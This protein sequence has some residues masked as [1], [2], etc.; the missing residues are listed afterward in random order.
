MRLKV[1]GSAI[2]IRAKSIR[3]LYSSIGKLNYW[4][5]IVF[6]LISFG[7]GQAI[8]RSAPMDRFLIYQILFIPAIVIA[9]K[10]IKI[11]IASAEKYK[12]MTASHPT[13]ETGAYISG[14]LQSHWAVPGV[15]AISSLYI[16]STISLKYVALN[17]TGYYALIM[18][19]FV[20]ISSVLGQ[21]CYIYYLLLLRK[22]FESENFK[23][24][25]HFPART[26]WMRLLTQMGTRLSNAFFVLGVI[27][28]TV[29]F[30]NMPSG[31]IRMSRSPWRIELS[32]PNNLAFLASWLTI[33]IIIILA[34]PMYAWIKTRYLTA[35]I[36]KLK[37][38]SISEI[39]MI[40][41]EGNVK[42]KRNI[43]AE[44]KCYQLM[45]N[46]EGS[47]IR[48]SIAS[49][50]LPVAATLSSITVHLIKISESF[51]P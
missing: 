31:Y 33:F 4:H 26:D 37:D 23:Y 35:I 24:N 45:V 42:G 11:F 2:T 44:L 10:E 47:L 48:T 9:I 36:R 7:A 17:P 28:T 50:I 3:G 1:R 30:L 32:T 20:M 18:I 51:S 46:I 41:T 49:S 5:A 12:T 25:F 8:N 13:R 34:F 43:D 14:L 29:F 38:I 15:I 6:I 40:M 16:Y 19:A 22:I 27:Y 21:T 39:E